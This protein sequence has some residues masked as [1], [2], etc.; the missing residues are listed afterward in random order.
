MLLDVAAVGVA[1]NMAG[2]FPAV[3][4]CCCCCCAVVAAVA[5]RAVEYVPAVKGCCF[6]VAVGGSVVVLLLPSVAVAV[7]E[8]HAQL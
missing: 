2:K 5:V 4:C 6:A 7:G 8:S 1:V 3:R